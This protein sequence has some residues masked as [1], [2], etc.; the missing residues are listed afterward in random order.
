[1]PGLKRTVLLLATLLS[2][3]L[4]HARAEQR[5]SAAPV[6]F[7][8]VLH[9]TGKET[10]GTATDDPITVVESTRIKR[11]RFTHRDLIAALRE[12]GTVPAK[13]KWELV[14]VWAD[15]PDAD[16][17]AGIGPRLFVRE[18]G[19]TVPRAKR[20]PTKL[21]TIELL[22]QVRAQKPVHDTKGRRTGGR[23][24]YHAL[25]RLTFKTGD[26]PALSSA[27]KPAA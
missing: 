18:K 4:T 9:Y 1:M 7:D 13:G 17:I 23:E 15:W 21:A 19:K 27:W 5:V 2:L 12:R 3:A 25:T 11:A 24:D 8:L 22:D 10:T 16:P 6:T 14:S 20:V 26:F